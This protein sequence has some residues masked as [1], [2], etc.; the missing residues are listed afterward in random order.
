MAELTEEALGAGA[1]GFTTSRTLLHKTARG[2]Y[3]PNF[4][5]AARELNA[6]VIVATA[7]DGKR[8]REGLGAELGGDAL[9][10]H[11]ARPPVTQAVLH[12][13]VQDAGDDTVLVPAIAREDDGDVRGLREIRRPRALA[14]L[15]VVVLRGEGQGVVDAIRVPDHCWSGT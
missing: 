5:A 2:E 10:E 9:I 1:L 6:I 7:R 14:D 8:E 4:G 12:H 11:L 13:V 3:V 15:A